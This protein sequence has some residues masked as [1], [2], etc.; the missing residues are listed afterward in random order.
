MFSYML[1]H[2]IYGDANT[3][4]TFTPYGTEYCSWRD[5]F[6]FFDTEI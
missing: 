6:F 2:I 1:N 3:S 5:T 4:V